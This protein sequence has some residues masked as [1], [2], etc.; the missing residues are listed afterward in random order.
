MKILSID[1]GI[2]NLAYC[3]LEVTS[4]D[5]IKKYNIIKW[6]VINLC[7]EIPTCQHIITTKKTSKKCDKK[8]CLFRGDVFYCKTHAKKMNCIMDTKENT[9]KKS[10]TLKVLQNLLTH[11]KIP[12]NSESKKNELYDKLKQHFD[13][14][15]FYSI[16][17][18]SASDMSLIDVG[19]SIYKNVPLHLD[20]ENIDTV[21]IENQI[22]PL[23]NRMKTI[24]GMVAQFFIMNNISDIHFIS[25]INKLK[26]FTQKKMN[27][28]ERK[29]HGIY[30]TKN[31]IK[32]NNTWSSLFNNHKK[33][34]D[35]A[36][37]LLQ[38]LWFLLDK[39]LVT[40][41]SISYK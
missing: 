20:I 3:L 13:E 38:G 1:I 24:Q 18:K 23:A 11:Y 15:M 28:K 2:K 36:D 7:G 27:Y 19:C 17:K 9:I 30:I 41:E 31:L 39:N 32:D 26:P 25:A 8:A 4:I 29:E 22:S 37:S 5:N 40:Q 21:I 14:N 33:K 16:K 35:L 12:Y 10:T 34:D 6:D